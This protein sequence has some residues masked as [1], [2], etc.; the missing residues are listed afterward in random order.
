MSYG[1]IVIGTSA[2]GIKALKEILTDLKNPRGLPIIILQHIS[3]DAKSCLADILERM[4][5]AYSY[6][7]SEGLRLYPGCIY[8]PA[9]GYHMV[10]HENLTLGLVDSPPVCYV[11]PAVDVLFESI[12]EHVGSRAIA[13]ILTG[14]NND[15]SQGMVKIQASGGYTMVQDPRTAYANRMPKSVLN[16]MEPDYVGTLAGIKKQLEIIIQDS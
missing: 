2:G 10:V 15:G 7:A 9:P 3:S 6:E 5:G 16:I 1:L 11:K 8:T 4:T 14:A 13:I 12:A